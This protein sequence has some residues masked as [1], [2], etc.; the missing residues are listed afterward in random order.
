MLVLKL[1]SGED[2]SDSNTSKR[3]I[4]IP[5]ASSVAFDRIDGKA[6]AKYID[7]DGETVDIE[8]AGN[9]YVLQN[10]KTIASFAYSSYSD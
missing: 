6:F 3:F 5:C 7:N 1:M 9:A 2:L 4:L 8:M 10:G